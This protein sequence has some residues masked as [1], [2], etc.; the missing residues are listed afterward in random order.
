MDLHYDEL[1]AEHYYANDFQPG[2]LSYADDSNSDLGMSDPEGQ[3]VPAA[4]ATTYATGTITHMA[5]MDHHHFQ[6]EAPMTNETLSTVASHMPATHQI[7]LE[8]ALPPG[9]VVQTVAHANPKPKPKS[10]KPKRS[11]QRPSNRSAGSGTII[12]KASSSSRQPQEH[13][14]LT[15]SMNASVEPPATAR[16]R[17]THDDMTPAPN[18]HAD[19]DMSDQRPAPAQP[20]MQTHT[21]A[22]TM[23]SL[24]S[25]IAAD[26]RTQANGQSTMMMMANPVSESL[27]L[28]NSMMPS[29]RFYDLV[30]IMYETSSPVM[31]EKMTWHHPMMV[32][33]ED[34]RSMT[35]QASKSMEQL[36]KSINGQSMD[37]TWSSQYRSLLIPSVNDPNDREGLRLQNR[38]RVELLPSMPSSSP[39]MYLYAVD[40]TCSL[41]MNFTAAEDKMYAQAVGSRFTPAY[42][43]MQMM[44]CYFDI[45]MPVHHSLHV[46]VELISMVQSTI[47]TLSKIMH[48]D[49]FIYMVH[50]LV[51][52]VG[53]MIPMRLYLEHCKAFQDARLP[54][55]RRNFFVHLS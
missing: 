47:G 8:N 39:Y 1:G 20:M 17:R 11:G 36:N 9:T 15:P 4:A 52:H 2:D 21:N 50:P 6:E 30:T 45:D 3:D 27:A 46:M 10:S 24:A 43:V 49:E 48:Q 41:M 44:T 34:L 37:E 25:R 32:F 5:T 22:S 16:I 33:I 23:N 14:A 40:A 13:P 42:T 51:P 54:L 38:S 18:G 26:A 53:L 31:K 55:I 19:H 35:A 7:S 28:P 29:T 12:A